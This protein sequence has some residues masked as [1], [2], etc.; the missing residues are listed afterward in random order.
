MVTAEVHQQAMLP[1]VKL[2]QAKLDGVGGVAI[3]LDLQAICHM[4]SRGA[5]KRG[6]QLMKREEQG[7][8]TPCTGATRNTGLG[9]GQ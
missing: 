4:K 6:D 8:P 3:G 7:E 2:L 5:V 9:A 1:Q